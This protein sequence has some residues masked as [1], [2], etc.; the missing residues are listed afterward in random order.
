MKI[1]HK[2]PVASD[3][4]LWSWCDIP[5]QRS[6]G[7]VFLR[8]LRILQTPW[9]GVYLHWINEE[10]HDRDPHE[11]PSTFW[12]LV[13]RGWYTE[14][15]FSRPGAT[16]DIVSRSR[17]SLHCMPRSKAHLITAAGERTVTL[18]VTGCRVDTWGFWTDSGFVPWRSYLKVDV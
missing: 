16:G 8:R 6:P 15:V 13:L 12:S 2:P 14:H 1:K 3:W 17:F 7:Q 10:D 18:V 11:H 5:S 9:F 4:A